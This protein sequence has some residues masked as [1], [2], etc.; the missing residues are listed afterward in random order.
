MPSARPRAAV[1]LHVLLAD[2]DP[3]R[4]ASVASALL[5]AGV[6]R[7]SRPN[8]GEALLDA[9][10]RLGPDVVIVDM[11][12]P[13]RDALDDLRHVSARHPRPVVMFTD[14]D[15]AEFMRDAIAA[16][17]SSYNVVGASL[18][19]IKPIIQAAIAIFGRFRELESG[20]RRAEASLQDRLLVDRAK[21]MLIRTRACSEPEA[22][23]WLRRQAMQRGRRIAEV[24]AE[25]LEQ[26]RAG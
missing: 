15:D 8:P 22:Y 1:R 10:R 14:R 3:K 9:V 19:D 16:G 26:D 18:P 25:L 23:R 13:D 2:N 5:E 21:A 7:M 17:V 24:A 12:R 4:A 6:D 11:G 20:L